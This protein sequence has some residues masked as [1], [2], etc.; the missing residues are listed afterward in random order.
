[1][2][3]EFILKRIFL[4]T[5]VLFIA[6]SVNGFVWILV[7]HDQS[8]PGV[9]WAFQTPEKKRAR[10]PS[11]DDVTSAAN[12]KALEWSVDSFLISAVG[13][14]TNWDLEIHY[15][16]GAGSE[17]IG[18]TDQKLLDGRCNFWTFTYY[19]PELMYYYTF[20][21][22]DR[23]NGSWGDNDLYCD[24]GD[25]MRMRPLT[26]F[27]DSD[28]IVSHLDLGVND[29][30]RGKSA[31]FYWLHNDVNGKPVWTLYHNNNNDIDWSIEMNARTGNITADPGIDRGL[32]FK[33][34]LDLVDELRIRP[35]G[36]YGL[37][38]VIGREYGSFNLP[39]PS[40]YH[41]LRRPDLKRGDGCVDWWTIIWISGDDLISFK[42]DIW[43]DGYYVEEN[44]SEW[45]DDWNYITNV[46]MDLL[47]DSTEAMDILKEEY[48]QLSDDI[49][50]DY[51]LRFYSKDDDVDSPTWEVEYAS[52]C[53]VIVYQ[54]D[55]YNGT[56][57]QEYRN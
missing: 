28:E 57:L 50:L 25:S 43:S 23:K 13:I 32:S 38:K 29:T 2:G 8:E 18:S 33:D 24:D 34:A 4:V 41:G 55:G 47:K 14:E 30:E 20:S 10:P 44:G 54:V 3:R 21:F 19:S 9:D 12:S 52:G 53:E 16:F 1:M 40:Y 35:Q 15:P 11:L 45:S 46:D 48:S 31:Y 36:E 56:I 49:Y 7:T 22:T 5:A 27:I 6:I 26:E 39:F 37:S 42:I 17:I 51:Q